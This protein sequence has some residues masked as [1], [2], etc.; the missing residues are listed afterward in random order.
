MKTHTLLCLLLAVL[1]AVTGSACADRKGN[2]LMDQGLTLLESYKK[3]NEFNPLYTQRFGADPGVME[4]DG[5]LY[6]YM[7][8]DIVEWK[9]DGTAL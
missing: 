4:Y 7:T 5:R 8:D 1:T 6:V 9:F 2:T 3:E